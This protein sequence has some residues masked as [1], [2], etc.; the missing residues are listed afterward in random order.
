M[1]GTT[2]FVHILQSDW[3]N[4]VEELLALA[5]IILAF[6]HARHLRN[7]LNRLEEV[8]R[9]LPTQH[10][11]KFPEFLD[12]IVKLVEGAK[13]KI[14][15]FCDYPGYGVFSNSDAFLAYTH[16][17][18]ERSSKGVRIRLACLDAP[19]RHA[20]A[21][22]EFARGKEWERWLKD[23][24]HVNRATKLLT[25]HRSTTNPSAVSR[26][27]IVELLGKEDERVLADTFA[28]P[29]KVSFVKVGVPLYFWLVD[30]NRALFALPGFREKAVEHGYS[31]H[32]PHLIE[33]LLEIRERYVS[34]STSSGSASTSIA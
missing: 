24:V 14:V 28:A 1:T 32:D 20:K 9:A 26:E 27:E 23:K 19:L 12:D 2:D 17:L 31:T 34:E 4:T 13:H 3:R 16:A 22:E 25:R 18:E 10:L 7:S 11:S 30:G 5:A 6:I 33:G 21:N 15:I 8:R 29:A